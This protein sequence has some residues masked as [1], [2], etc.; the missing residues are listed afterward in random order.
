VKLVQAWHSSSTPD[1]VYTGNPCGFVINFGDLTF[2]HPGD[3]CLFGDMKLIAEMTPID[4]FFC[5][6]GDHFTMGVADGVKAV[7]LVNPGLVIPMHYNTFDPI[8]QDPENFKGLVEKKFT[9]IKVVVMAP[10]ATHEV[11]SKAAVGG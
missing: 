8:K 9:G 5:P 7:E 10:G 1:G 11:P 3:T 4:V 6:I 2:Y